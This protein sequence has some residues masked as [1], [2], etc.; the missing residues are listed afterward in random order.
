MSRPVDFPTYT[1]AAITAIT[2][3]GGWQ[4]SISDSTGNGGRMAY[5]DTTNS[6]WNY[7]SDDTAV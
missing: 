5:W 6:R 4:V 7:V 3:A 2:G 1:K